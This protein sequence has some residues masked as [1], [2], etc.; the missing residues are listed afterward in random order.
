MGAFPKT[1]T[2]YAEFLERFPRLAKAWEEIAL[3]GQTGPLDARIVRLLKLAMSMGAL[4]E[5]AV[6][7]SVRKGLLLGLRK[8]EIEQVA[9]IAAG[10]IGLPACVAVYSWIQDE[11]EKQRASAQAQRTSATNLNE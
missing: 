9:T 5:G 3:T 11:L 10:T 1:P 4:R 7:A 2:R 8:E 6:R